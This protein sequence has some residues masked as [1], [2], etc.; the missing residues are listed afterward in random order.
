MCGEG[1]GGGVW[2]QE[3]CE[4]GGSRPGLPVANSPYGFFGRKATLKKMSMF[5]SSEDV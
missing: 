5:R 3:L 4:S 1:G 2:A